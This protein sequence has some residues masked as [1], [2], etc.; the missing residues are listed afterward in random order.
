[1]S[2]TAKS[3]PRASLGASSSTPSVGGIAVPEANSPLGPLGEALTQVIHLRGT[4]PDH[5]DLRRLLAEVERLRR[6]GEG[7]G[8]KL[9]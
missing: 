9:V 3:T 7:V 4:H 8:E 5:R 6:A 1:M 2:N